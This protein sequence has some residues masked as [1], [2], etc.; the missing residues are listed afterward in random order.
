MNSI[1]I[2]HLSEGH[3]V[4][5]IVHED[6]IALMNKPLQETE[7]GILKSS[8]ESGVHDKIDDVTCTGLT[9]EEKL[10]SMLVGLIGIVDFD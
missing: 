5:I 10:Q 2:Q 6:M 7:N 4:V 8:S 1:V 3:G 9:Q